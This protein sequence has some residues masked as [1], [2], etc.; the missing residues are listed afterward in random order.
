MRGAEHH[1]S[2]QFCAGL[3]QSITN[4]TVGG[5]E[6]NAWRPVGKN[7]PRGDKRYRKG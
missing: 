7:A 1:R 3:P 4:D 6:H 5:F 2:Y